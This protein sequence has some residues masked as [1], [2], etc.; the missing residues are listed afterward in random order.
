[1]G[2]AISNPQKEK[3]AEHSLNKT[4]KEKKKAEHIF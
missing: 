2:I 4:K 1:M 3:K